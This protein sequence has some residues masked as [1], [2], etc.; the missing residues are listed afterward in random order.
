ME[1]EKR[2]LEFKNELLETELARLKSNDFDEKQ[3]LDKSSEAAAAAPGDQKSSAC[4]K[5]F[6]DQLFKIICNSSLND[7]EKF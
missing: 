4:R 3:F 2:E 1:E 5:I 6:L 7:V